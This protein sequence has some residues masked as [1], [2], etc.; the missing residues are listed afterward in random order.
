WDEPTSKPKK[1]FRDST[2]AWIDDP[3]EPKFLADSSFLFPSE[4]TGYKHLYLYGADGTLKFPVTTGEWEV[5]DVLRVDEKDRTVLFAGTKDGHTRLHLYKAWFAGD[6]ARRLTN[7]GG[8]HSVSVAPAGN[9]Y[10]DRHTDN[11]TPTQVF[12]NEVEEDL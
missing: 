12:L 8:N 11:A 4:R 7:L 10:I 2:K 5:R 1:L 6:L 9:L 3:G